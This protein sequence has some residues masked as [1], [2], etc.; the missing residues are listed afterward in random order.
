MR[1]SNPSK[2]GTGKTFKCIYLTKHIKYLKLNK[3][4]KINQN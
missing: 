4:I 1:K 2:T 3:F